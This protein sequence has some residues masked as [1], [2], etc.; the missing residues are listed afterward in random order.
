MNTAVALPRGCTN[1]KTRQLGRLLSRRYD[2]ELAKVGLKTTQFSLLSQVLAHGPVAPGELAR[3]MGLD[4]STLTRNLR[5]LVEAGWLS[6]DAGA[7]ARTRV[8]TIT[9]AGRQRQAEA[10]RCWKTAQLD[11]NAVLGVERVSALHG[12]LEECMQL[13]QTDPADPS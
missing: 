11:I 12:L 9:P 2:S 4:A 3:L 1:F 10:K 5:P 13:L 7:D 8:V 6:Q